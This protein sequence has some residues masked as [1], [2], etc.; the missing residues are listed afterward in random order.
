MDGE[1]EMSKLSSQ[2]SSSND[3]DD[4]LESAR[5]SSTLAESEELLNK[6]F[7]RGILEEFIS[8]TKFTCG[9]QC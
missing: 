7:F 4:M 3:V 2:L 6:T 5:F 1:L 8:E 9:Y